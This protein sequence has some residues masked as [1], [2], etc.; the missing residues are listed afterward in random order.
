VTVG[1]FRGFVAA[2]K[3]GWTPAA[4]SGKHAHLNGGRGLV[5]VG[6]SGGYEVGWVT[7]DNQNVSPTD[8]NLSCDSP[9]G[10]WTPAP[11]A[12]ENL[13]INCVNWSEAYAFCIWD[14]GFLPSEAE[15]EYAAAGGDQ[16]RKYPWGSVDPG[17]ANQYAIYNCDYPASAGG[18]CGLP[19]TVTSIAPV[20]T[21]ILGAGRWGHFDLAGNLEQWTVDWY[22]D[23]VSPCV[24]CAYLTTN[25]R[26][27]YRVFRGGRFN[28]SPP[29]LEPVARGFFGP[30]IGGFGIRC[31]RSP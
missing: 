20:G 6:P 22:A 19:G 25:P 12:N 9:G 4:G 15:W 28:E 13:P 18:A 14:G 26:L 11:G 3:A 30:G 10:S 21:T 8:G 1:R 17:D 24:D 7:S 29:Q 31:A 27:P 5:N 23:Y 2:W 16:Q